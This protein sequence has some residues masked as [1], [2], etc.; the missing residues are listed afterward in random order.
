[1]NIGAIP[2][3]I[4]PFDAQEPALSNGRARFGITI[5]FRYTVGVYFSPLHRFFSKN[6]LYFFSANLTPE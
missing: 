4:P 5:R 2:Y 6:D 1:M 3:L